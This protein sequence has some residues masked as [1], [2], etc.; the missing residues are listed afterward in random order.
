[1]HSKKPEKQG[2]MLI[3]ELVD[4]VP[5]IIT[6]H[7]LVFVLAR[8]PCHARICHDVHMVM[9]YKSMEFTGLF[10]RSQGASEGRQ[11]ARKH[12]AGMQE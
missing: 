10:P 11:Q 2:K 6:V 9:H 4:L 8:R 7:V 3:N 5:F 1:L 12:A